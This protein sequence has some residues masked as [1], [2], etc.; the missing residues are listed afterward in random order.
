MGDF[1]EQAQQL[2]QSR[3]VAKAHDLFRFRHP[4]IYY[5]F[6]A[7]Y[8]RDH[9]DESTI[10]AVVRDLA[11]NLY[12]EE[13][14]STLLFLAH[15]SKDRF[16]LNTLVAA[17][18]AQFTE[19]PVATLQRDVEF[20]NKIESTVP[21][22]PIA[23][24]NARDAREELLEAADRNEEQQRKFEEQQQAQIENASSA[25]GRLNAALKT[26]QILGQILKNFP[27]DFE[28]D[29]KDRIITASCALGRR[30]L[31][32]LLQ[33]IEQNEALLLQDM[34]RLITRRRSSLSETKLRERA[35]SAIFA[36]SELAATGMVVRISHALGSKDLTATYER[37]FPD[38]KV[39]MLRLVYAALRLEHYDEF[40]E[41]LIRKG[42]KALRRNPFA[43]RVLRDLV[44][45]YLT[46]FPA[47][48]RLKQ[49]LSEMLHL[50]FQTV[51]APKPTQ[52]LLK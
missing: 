26:I 13:S 4:Y 43:F 11:A 49:R 2:I 27:A 30:V 12:R 24:R 10:Q 14:A 16:V 22:L 25:L 3:L 40:P 45:R 47:D 44:V 33:S 50:D 5:Y 37:V 39:S 36:L 15:L 28:R 20:L 9:L 19:A 1:R 35:A 51:R 42:A 48:F 18:E 7:A 21:K 6:L 32:S 23:D 29:D 46:M 31:G 17:A 52:R 38:V 8:L 41:G 34:I